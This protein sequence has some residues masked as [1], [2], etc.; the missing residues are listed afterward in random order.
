MTEKTAE[1]ITEAYVEQIIHA[2][3]E[4]SVETAEYMIT[5]LLREYAAKAYNAGRRELYENIAKLI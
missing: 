4:L 3:Q 2:A 1:E 5:E